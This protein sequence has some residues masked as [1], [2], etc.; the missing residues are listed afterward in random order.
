MSTSTIIHRFRSLLTRLLL[1]WLLVYTAAPARG[2][3]DESERHE[4]TAA[5]VLEAQ[6]AVIQARG[7]YLKA[8]GEYCGRQA[9][10]AEKW[11]DARSKKLQNDKTYV[12]DYYAKK[13]IRREYTEVTAR[14]PMNRDRAERLAKSNTP[15]RLH[16]VLPCN[17]NSRFTATDGPV[18]LTWPVVLETSD[19]DRLRE[20]VEELWSRRWT[21]PSGMGTRNCWEIQQLS[22]SMQSVLDTQI[23]DLAPSDYMFAKRFLR[24]LAYEAEFP[25]KESHSL[26]AQH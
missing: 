26:L 11:Q 5:E 6:A 4:A 2:E 3:D 16:E 25:C 23:H 24:S 17:A 20:D 12:A 9:E 7:A 13:L 14:P 19:F 8:M 22:R 10:A 1:L 15:P 18:P 21:E